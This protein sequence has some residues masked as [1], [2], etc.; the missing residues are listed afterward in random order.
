MGENK[1]FILSKEGSDEL[2]EWMRRCCGS[3]IEGFDDVMRCG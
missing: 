3:I 2:K 1:T